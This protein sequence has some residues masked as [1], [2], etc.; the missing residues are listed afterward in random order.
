MFVGTKQ[1]ILNPSFALVA[2][3]QKSIVLTPKWSLPFQGQLGNAQ[4]DIAAASKNDLVKDVSKIPD[5]DL[6]IFKPKKV[7]VLTLT[8]PETLNQTLLAD[9]NVPDIGTASDTIKQNGKFIAGE[10]SVWDGP[11]DG[12]RIVN[13]LLEIH[14]ENSAEGKTLDEHV[15]IQSGL[16]HR[17]FEVA[18]DGMNEFVEYQ[19]NGP[20]MR[21]GQLILDSPKCKI[22]NKAWADY[23]RQRYIDK[24][25][26]QVV[27]C[28]MQLAEGIGNSENEQG[29]KAIAGAKEELAALV[30]GEE[31]GRAVKALTIWLNNIQVPYATFAQAP[32]NT[33]EHVKKLE[34]VVAAA[35]EHD[36]VITEVTKRVERYA[37]PNALKHRSAQLIQTA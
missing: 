12:D 24:I 26:G 30:G 29:A 17:V 33:S 8:P 16:G 2:E 36:P 22:R 35:I 25:H 34:Q 27:T 3:K 9:A 37:Y 21:V 18:R 6:A 19:G 32:W 7:Q 11:F 31:A 1:P 4:Q 28:L 10:I 20:S 5:N 13:H 15:K 14:F 23:A